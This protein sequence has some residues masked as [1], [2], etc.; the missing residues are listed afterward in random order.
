MANEGVLG[1]FKVEGEKAA[2]DDHPVIIHALLLDSGVTGVLPAGLLLER[3]GAGDYQPY[4]SGTPC[5]V[6]NEP[7]DSAVESSAK[8]VVHG[9]VKARLLKTGTNAADDA[10]IAALMDHGVFAV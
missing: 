5:A 8:S 2:T 9:C 3:T 4:S 1:K 10:A 6:V 7:C